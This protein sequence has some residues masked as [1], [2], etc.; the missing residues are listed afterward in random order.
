M[1][2]T[3]HL[4]TFNVQIGRQARRLRGF[5]LAQKAPQTLMAR[6]AT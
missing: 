2:A 6:L 4:S 3:P 5:P 1:G